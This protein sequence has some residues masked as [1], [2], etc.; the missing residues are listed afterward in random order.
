MSRASHLALLLENRYIRA[1]TPGGCYKKSQ[2]LLIF[3]GYLSSAFL[4]HSWSRALS[5]W[6]PSGSIFGQ[7]F[8]GWMQWPYDFVHKYRSQQCWYSRFWTMPNVTLVRDS[9]F[10]KWRV[11]FP[12]AFNY[13]WSVPRLSCKARWWI[14]YSQV[15]SRTSTWTRYGHSPVSRMWIFVRIREKYNLRATIKLLFLVLLSKN[16]VLL[17]SGNS[18]TSR[19]GSFDCFLKLFPVC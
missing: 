12:D 4:L 18:R 14:L 13:V 6:A 1:V 19:S 9:G 7:L 17:V 3:C 10:R 11:I 5:K 16:D 2:A 15:R 8:F